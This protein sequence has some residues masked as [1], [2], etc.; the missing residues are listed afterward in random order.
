MLLSLR[1]P[2]K[3]AAER[4]IETAGRLSPSRFRRPLRR[5]KRSDP[6]RPA[7][8]RPLKCAPVPK[9]CQKPLFANSGITLRPGSPGA[10]VDRRTQAAQ[11]MAGPVAVRAAP[12]EGRS[13]TL[14]AG[15]AAMALTPHR[16]TI[17]TVHRG[18][19]CCISSRR[20]SARPQ[21]TG[22]ETLK[23]LLRRGKPHKVSCDAPV[24]AHR[25]S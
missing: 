23:R 10:C 14:R 16:R 22:V 2:P 24:C 3:R 15:S 8:V 12:C 11:E 18:C 13:V 25:A 6:V 7:S 5:P 20:A 9:E 4:L 19:A 17:A 21:N 1:L